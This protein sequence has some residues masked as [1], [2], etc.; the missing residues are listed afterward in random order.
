[1]F[2]TTNMNNTAISRIPAELWLDIF[3]LL[4]LPRNAMH[5]SYQTRE[6]HVLAAKEV[7]NVALTCRSLAVCILFPVLL[8]C[9][10][11]AALCPASCIPTLHLE[12]RCHPHVRV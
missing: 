2:I 6:H 10:T 7:H 8:R 11:P 5:I 9:L 1:M 12:G 3:D 4:V